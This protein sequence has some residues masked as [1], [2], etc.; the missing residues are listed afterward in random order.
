M[1]MIDGCSIELCVYARMPQKQT[2]S[3]LHD[4]LVIAD[5]C[6]LLGLDKIHL[7]KSQLEV[8]ILEVYLLYAYLHLGGLFQTQ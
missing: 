6:L 7:R 2:H 8:G 3:T 5:I 1:Q 4:S